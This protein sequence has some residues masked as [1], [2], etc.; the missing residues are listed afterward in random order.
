[1]GSIIRLSHLRNRTVFIC[2]TGKTVLP[3]F[4]C[5][6]TEVAVAVKHWHGGTPACLKLMVTAE[7][8]HSS[9]HSS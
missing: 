1:M 6:N 7:K 5:R 9:L 4:Y 8:I 3:R 2:K